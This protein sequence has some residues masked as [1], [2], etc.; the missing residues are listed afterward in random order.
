VFSRAVLIRPFTLS[1]D[2]GFI[3]KYYYQRDPPKLKLS[4]GLW[5]LNALTLV[6]HQLKRQL[7]SGHMCGVELLFPIPNRT[8]KRVS[9]EDTWALC[10]GKICHGRELSDAFDW[11]VN[12]YSNLPTIN[13]AP[14]SRGGFFLC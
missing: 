11:L 5:L 6:K 2:L 14:L 13:L 8:V 9:A 12:K 3:T 7:F 1:T 10:P 4:R